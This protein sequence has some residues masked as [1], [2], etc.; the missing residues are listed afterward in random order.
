MTKLHEFGVSFS[1]KDMIMLE[2]INEYY[3]TKQFEYPL[4]GSKTLVRIED[5]ENFTHLLITRMDRKINQPP[6][7]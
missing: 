1:K 7:S 5:L 2:A 3:K 6:I 4:V